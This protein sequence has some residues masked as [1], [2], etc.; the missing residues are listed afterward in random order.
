VQAILADGTGKTAWEN[1]SQVYVPS[2]VVHQGRLYAMADN[3]VATCWDS[4]T[5]KVQWTSRVGGNFSSSLVLV[6]ELLY[7]TS[8]SGKTTIFRADPKKFELVAENTLGDEVY[9]SPAICGGRIYMRVVEN[10]PTRQEWLY[11]IGE[12]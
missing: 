7:A 1:T 11:A 12:K 3:G 6:G 8:E 9:A 4:A 2:M 10:T 5:G